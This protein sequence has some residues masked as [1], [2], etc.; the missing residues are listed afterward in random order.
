MIQEL[1]RHCLVFLLIPRAPRSTR[2]DTLFP[3]PTLF[4]SPPATIRRSRHWMTAWRPTF[5]ISWQPTTGTGERHGS[6]YLPRFRP[7][8]H[9]DRPVRDPV[10]RA[11]LYRRAAARLA[12]LPAARQTAAPPGRG[13]GARRPPRL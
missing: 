8:R 4:R 10:V 13:A 7:Y 1:V 2:T 11:C 5:A 12:L 9:F 6:V 3:Y